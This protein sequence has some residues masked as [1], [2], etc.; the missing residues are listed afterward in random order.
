LEISKL[1]LELLDSDKASF[2]RRL[3][4]PAHQFAWASPFPSVDSSEQ[5]I[6]W[7]QRGVCPCGA[8]VR[9]AASSL[10]T[11]SPDV[12]KPCPLGVDEAPDR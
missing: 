4:K 5:F 2:L 11:A 12:F 10:T 1:E 6:N 8:W 7:T 3:A 9:L